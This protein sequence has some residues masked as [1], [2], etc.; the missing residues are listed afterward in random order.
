MI[1][2]SLNPLQALKTKARFDLG[3]HFN[4]EA[5]INA[6]SDMAL[7]V[8]IAKGA[9]I[10]HPIEQRNSRFLSVMKG[11]DEAKTA[12]DIDVAM[13]VIHTAYPPLPPPEEK[14]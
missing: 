3:N 4:A 10:V 2:L 8:A 11:I 1:T 12:E 6:H 9:K 7:A 14:A 13:S 5:S